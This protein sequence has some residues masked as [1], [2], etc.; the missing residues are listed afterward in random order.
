MST[1]VTQ[2]VTITCDGPECPNTST[3]AQTKEGEAAAIQANPWL[4]NIRFVQS[5]PDQQHQEGT[6]FVYCSDQCEI[7]A[8]GA[9]NHNKKQIVVPT[10]PNAVELQAQAAARAHAATAALKS[11]EGKVVLG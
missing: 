10:G 4:T 6:R 11:G 5:P 2:F 1:I 3:F 9:G 8:A 7:K